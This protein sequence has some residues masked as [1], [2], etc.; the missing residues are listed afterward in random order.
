KTA[1]ARRMHSGSARDQ[2][3]RIHAELLR[4]TYPTGGRRSRNGT[5]TEIFASPAPPRR[6]GIDGVFRFF[7][8]QRTDLPRDLSSYVYYFHR[9]YGPR[10]SNG[11]GDIATL[12]DGRDEG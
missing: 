4:R 8:P 1:G 7:S 11:C 2:L 5:E 3:H 9:L 10:N 6:A 12:H